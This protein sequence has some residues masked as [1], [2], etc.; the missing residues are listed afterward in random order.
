M[1]KLGLILCIILCVVTITGCKKNNE[2]MVQSDRAID[3]SV[4]EEEAI[5]D[6]IPTEA[7]EGEGGGN[8]YSSGSVEMEV[9]TIQ[10]LVNKDEY[11]YEN[12]PIELTEFI[13]MI[14]T[15][16]GEIIVEITDNNATYKAYSKL[17][18]ELQERE[19]VYTEQ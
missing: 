2:E 9:T 18:D 5:S 14:E 11:F 3:S 1:R 16:E 17:T 12:T 7:P 6:I 13:S 19:I 10:I 15:I 8:K 4:T